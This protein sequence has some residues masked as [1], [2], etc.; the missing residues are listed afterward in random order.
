M[1]DW[2]HAEFFNNLLDPTATSRLQQAIPHTQLLHAHPKETLWAERKQKVFKPTTG[3]NLILLK[4]PFAVR[5]FVT[6]P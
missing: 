2:S 4:P 3:V 5:K 6:W 1:A